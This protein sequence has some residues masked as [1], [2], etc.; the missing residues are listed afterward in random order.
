MPSQLHESVVAD[1]AKVGYKTHGAIEFARLTYY[2]EEELCIDAR[3][4]LSDFFNSG[5][6][7]N[8]HNA[9][10]IAR[11][12]YNAQ[13]DRDMCPTYEEARDEVPIPKRMP[14]A[15]RYRPSIE[16][17]GLMAIEYVEVF[18]TCRT[19]LSKVADYGRGFDHFGS[20]QFILYEIG[21]NDNSTVRHDPLHAFAL[22][23]YHELNNDQPDSP[24]PSKIRQAYAEH[25][26][27]GEITVQND[28]MVA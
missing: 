13:P 21:A 15:W 9:K 2:L 8:H 26:R 18:D 10:R 23:L 22:A 6:R 24:L 19:E 11:D 4:I 27:T 28:L 16:C 1:L 17:E 20:T 14:D 5:K 12:V 3:S 7:I 25:L